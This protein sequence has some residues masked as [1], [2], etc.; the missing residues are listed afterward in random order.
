MYIKDFTDEEL[1]GEIKKCEPTYVRLAR[2]ERLYVELAEEGM[3]RLRV[4]FLGK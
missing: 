3:R 2:K 1:Q 4:K